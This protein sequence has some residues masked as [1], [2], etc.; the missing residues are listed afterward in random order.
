MYAPQISTTSTETATCAMGDGGGAA[1][2]PERCVLTMAM[3]F[4]TSCLS[5]LH[6][7]RAVHVSQFKFFEFGCHKSW[8]V[9]PVTIS[10]KL[11]MRHRVGV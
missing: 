8:Q 7:H 10:H 2:I 4:F 6:E 1:E 3:F 11:I 5:F 9:A